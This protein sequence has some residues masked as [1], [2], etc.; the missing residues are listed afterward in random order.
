[1]DLFNIFL[2]KFCLH[3]SRKI[4]SMVP[5][6]KKFVDDLK[7]TPIWAFFLLL[8][9]FLKSLHITDLLITL[10]KMVFFWLFI[11]S[12]IFQSFCIFLTVVSD[13]T[14]RRFSISDVTRPKIFH[15]LKAAEFGKL[16]FTTNLILVECLVKFMRL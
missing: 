13:R 14:A 1:M 7:S 2:N 15:T 10:I 16:F 9:I 11:C 4:S 6:F 8:V 5:L 3:D 12:Q